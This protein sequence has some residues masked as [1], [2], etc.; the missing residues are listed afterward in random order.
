MG[1]KIPLSFNE[2]GVKVN[3]Q[4]YLKF[5]DDQLVSSQPEVGIHH[6]QTDVQV[7]QV[8]DHLINIHDVC[9]MFA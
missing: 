4:V 2:T 6:H 3:K 9:F 1:E 7:H 8:R 5:L